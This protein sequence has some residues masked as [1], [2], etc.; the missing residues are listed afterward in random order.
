M[1]NADAFISSSML[2]EQVDGAQLMPNGRGHGGNQKNI[3][4][5]KLQVNPILLNLHFHL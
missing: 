3:K 1:S 4:V 2:S 5:S